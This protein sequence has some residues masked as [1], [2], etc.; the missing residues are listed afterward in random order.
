MNDS[1]IKMTPSYLSTFNTYVCVYV[2]FICL[3]WKQI[4]MMQGAH[5]TTQHLT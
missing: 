5:S 3:A 4:C 1:N 2:V